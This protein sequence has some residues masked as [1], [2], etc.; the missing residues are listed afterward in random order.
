MISLSCV[1]VD[2]AG[3]AGGMSGLASSDLSPDLI[4]LDIRGTMISA[5]RPND[6]GALEDGLRLADNISFVEGYSVFLH[7]AT[8]CT[9]P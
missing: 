1:L 4:V 6:L 8:C 2:A 5:Q 7:M 3:L 9:Q